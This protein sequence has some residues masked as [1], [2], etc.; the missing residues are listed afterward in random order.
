MGGTVTADDITGLKYFDQLAPL[1]ERL[2]DA[3]CERDKAGNRELHFDQ[4]CAFPAFTCEYSRES[5]PYKTAGASVRVKNRRF[6]PRMSREFRHHE[7]QLS[8]L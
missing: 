2:H 4:Y 6:C 7:V 5:R 3:A 1:L 8:K